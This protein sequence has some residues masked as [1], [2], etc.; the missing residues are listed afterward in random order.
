M[1]WDST[2]GFAETEGFRCGC[3]DD[4]SVFD[5]E[6]RKKLKLKE[7]PLIFMDTTFSHYQGSC[8]GLA[9]EKIIKMI[10]QS[11][12]YNGNPVL[13]W[14]NSGLNSEFWRQKRDIYEEIIS[15]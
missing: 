10:N 5:I 2:L 13:L 6:N 7:R 4:F 8:F 15:S 14:H 11:R 1:E 12:K 3:C 9:K